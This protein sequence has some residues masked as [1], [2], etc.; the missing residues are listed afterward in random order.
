MGQ[1]LTLEEKIADTRL[2]VEPNTDHDYFGY[3]VLGYGSQGFVPS[4]VFSTWIK[5]IEGLPEDDQEKELA[6]RANNYVQEGPLPEVPADRTRMFTLTSNNTLLEVVKFNNSAVF[7]AYKTN[8]KDF[9]SREGRW[10]RKASPSELPALKEAH[11]LTGIIDIKSKTINVYG[12]GYAGNIDSDFA[13]RISTIEELPIAE[14]ESATRALC[15]EAAAKA[16]VADFQIIEWLELPEQPEQ[17]QND[18]IAQFIQMMQMPAGQDDDEQKDDEQADDEDVTHQSS[19]ENWHQLLY[20]PSI[21]P[22]LHSRKYSGYAKPTH[23]AGNLYPE[24]PGCH[25][26]HAPNN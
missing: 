10:A 2:R 24:C 5:E 13:N 11:L 16:P 23:D 18:R 15:L 12:F 25:E 17:F 1:T 14:V 26:N 6:R 3:D 19:D 22:F 7:A 4:V 8:P 21:L 9:I 20:E